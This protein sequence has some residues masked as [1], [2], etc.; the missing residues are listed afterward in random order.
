MIYIA[1]ALIGIVSGMISGVVGTGSSIILLPILAYIFGAKL[2]VPIMAI[3]SI[4]GNISRV[5]LWR[6]Q[7]NI[8][9]FLLFTSLGIP[10]TVLG[11]KTLWI[12]PATLSNICIG[13][14]FIVL[15]PIHRYTK[16]HQLTI[17]NWQMVI[18]G[19]ILGYITGVVFSTGPLLLPV[20]SGFG[21]TKGALLATEAAA[22]FAIY[23]TKSLT[24]GALGVLQKE[25][26]I[27]GVAVGCSLMV[28]N[29]LGKSFVLKMSEKTFNLALDAMLLLAGCSMLW[30]AYFH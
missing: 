28:G 16:R 1:L 20:F 23:F 24:F 14:F 11:A 30:E 5:I 2:A 4:M 6:K 19:G 13:L 8:K 7:L 12:M 3:A 25:I 21:L 9:A 10:A 15:I 18:I 17:K 22:S 26:L 27:A 29:Y